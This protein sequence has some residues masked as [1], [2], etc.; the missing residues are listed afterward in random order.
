MVGMGVGWPLDTHGYTHAVPYSQILLVL[1]CTFRLALMSS[2]VDYPS[3][4][5]LEV[6]TILRVEFI[7]LVD[8]SFQLQVLPLAMLLLVCLI[9]C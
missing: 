4:N 1:S 3:I 5:V 9:L 7:I 6:Q 2:M 8:A